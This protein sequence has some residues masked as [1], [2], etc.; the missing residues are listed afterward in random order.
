MRRI[1]SWLFQLVHR[2][3]IACR[4]I[5]FCFCLL[6]IASGGILE[7]KIAQASDR[8]AKVSVSAIGPSEV[9]WRYGGKCAY[10]GSRQNPPAPVTPDS[11]PRAVRTKDGK[12]DIFAVNRINLRMVANKSLSEF[13]IPDCDQMLVSPGSPDPSTFENFV[14]VLAP[15]T[16]DGQE[17][18]VLAHNEYHGYLYNRGCDSTDAKDPYDTRCFYANLTSYVGNTKDM[19]LIHAP[20]VPFVAAAIQYRFNP[21]MNIAGIQQPTN[22]FH[23]PRDNYFYF[24]AVVSKY[25]QQHGGNW[26][27]CMFRTRDP[28]SDPWMA[29]S[30]HNWEAMGNP[31][32]Q[33]D[34]KKVTCHPVLHWHLSEVVYDP[35][36]DNFIGVGMCPGG[37]C[38]SASRDLLNMD[39]PQMLM[40]IQNFD[41]WWQ[42]PDNQNPIAYV[43]ILDPTSTS[44]NFDTVE[45]TPW[46]YF[47]KWILHDGRPAGDREIVRVPLQITHV[48]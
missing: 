38:Y 25:K 42:R 2:R 23:N 27:E 37:I 36:S 1:V 16:R 43:S 34:A 5:Y 18:Y 20:N 14:W 40:R 41:Q 7:P 13:S 47:V 11:P 35:A 4:A 30:G 21:D 45:S 26:S 28:F 24:Y 46:L 39:R 15:F 29:W 31:Y 8:P 19:K 22:I 12:V 10:L 3:C 44:R 9:V 33:S 6:I 17:I 48:K 32:L